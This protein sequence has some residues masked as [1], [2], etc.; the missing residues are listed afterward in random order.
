MCM[1]DMQGMSMH[2]CTM[3]RRQARV[4]LA[5]S[6]S[7]SLM[8]NHNQCVIKVNLTIAHPPNCNSSCQFAVSFM[9]N[10]DK[11]MRQIACVGF[12]ASQINKALAFPL[13]RVHQV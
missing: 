5:N 11:L 6:H 8:E 12:F 13:Q 4:V 7:T 3:V 10:A 1:H 2:I 9:P